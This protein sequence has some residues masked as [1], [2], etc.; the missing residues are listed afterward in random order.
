MKQAT[1]SDLAIKSRKNALKEYVANLASKTDGDLH[2]LTRS[3]HNLVERAD[4]A[5]EPCHR[6]TDERTFY[7]GCACIYIYIYEDGLSP[8]VQSMDC[9]HGAQ[10]VLSRF[11]V[12]LGLKIN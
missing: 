8:R 11:P 2:K 10:T 7:V 4:P 3:A 6:R 12:N 9:C 1:K 5:E